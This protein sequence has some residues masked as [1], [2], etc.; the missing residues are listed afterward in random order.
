[1]K[2][3]IIALFIFICSIQLFSQERNELSPVFYPSLYYSDKVEKDINLSLLLTL[4]PFH[5][6]AMGY[7]DLSAGIGYGIIPG[8]WYIGIAGNMSLG[9]SWL[10][11]FAMFLGEDSEED[12]DDR[13]EEED[14]DS[15]PQVGFNLGARVYSVFQLRNFRIASFAGCDFLMIKFPMP[16]VGLE[17]AYKLFGIEYAYYFPL[18]NDVP[19]RHRIS[20]KLHLPKEF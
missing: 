4:P 11:L 12:E 16:Y 6:S 18:D 1:M 8:K 17:L 5:E 2:S 13:P 3:F 15:I 9:T 7:V 20:I 19:T 10:E 14:D